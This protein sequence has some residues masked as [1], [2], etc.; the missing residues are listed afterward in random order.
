M[1]IFTRLN[2]LIVAAILIMLVT[3]LLLRAQII[4]Q[5]AMTFEYR[6]IAMKENI[7]NR[8]QAN[9]FK[10]RI[11]LLLYATSGS[12]QII[13]RI[14]KVDSLIAQ[15]MGDLSAQSVADKATLLQIETKMA[16]YINAQEV[17]LTQLE[18]IIR[19]ANLAAEAV[20]N[21]SVH[22]Q[23]DQTL[24]DLIV[25]DLSALSANPRSFDFLDG[26]KDSVKS[27]VFN[28]KHTKPTDQ[29]WLEQLTQSMGVLS[30]SIEQAREV[31]SVLRATGEPLSKTIEDVKLR[32]KKQQDTLGPALRE[33]IAATER[34]I[35]IAT[36]L[37]VVL[38]LVMV[39][40]LQT[41]ILLT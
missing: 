25:S 33:K 1:S 16:T 30:R 38:L 26:L 37:L 22:D 20:A 28:D 8:L 15:S 21:M 39:A 19:H 35:Q 31:A 17:Y 2:V 3:F 7:A 40:G 4:E 27:S 6:Q 36:A 12:S 32:L 14:E 10:K 29:P 9:L 5:D 13:D 23:A 34:L 11:S 18:D 24:H 41:L